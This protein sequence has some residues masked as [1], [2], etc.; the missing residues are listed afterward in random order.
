MGGQ[1]VSEGPLC[2]QHLWLDGFRPGRDI[3]RL[4]TSGVWLCVNI[5]S[6]VW[7][8]TMPCS[9]LACVWVKPRTLPSVSS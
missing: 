9:N 4:E 8:L 5:C 3:I 2:R 7:G 6:C 1:A